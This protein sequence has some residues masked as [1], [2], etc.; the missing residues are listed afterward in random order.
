MNAPIVTLAGALLLTACGGGTSSPTVPAPIAPS[1]SPSSSAT[2]WL[3]TQ[4]F[5]SVDGPDNCWVREQRARLTGLV[6]RELPMAITRSGS[7]ITL[8]GEFFEVNYAGTF[9]GP[10][11]SASGGGPLEGG[12]RPCQDGAS[13]QQTAGVSNLSGRFSADDQQMAATEVNSYH[14]TSGEPVTYTWDWQAA[15][16]N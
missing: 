2:H 12:G 4:R 6:F 11:F 9:S 1:P 5:V 8:E 15:R 13:F 16:R 10:E 3:V 7:S 14:L